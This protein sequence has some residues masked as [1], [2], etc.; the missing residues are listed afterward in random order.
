MPFWLIE[1]PLWRVPMRHLIVARNDHTGHFPASLMLG[2]IGGI[3]QGPAGGGA[4]QAPIDCAMP[5]GVFAHG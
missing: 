2:W 5:A 3:P 1:S 4:R